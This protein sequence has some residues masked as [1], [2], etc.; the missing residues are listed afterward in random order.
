MR[1][2]K[3]NLAIDIAI[4]TAAIPVFA[5]GFVLL[6]G[7]HV[8]HGIFRESVFHLGRHVWLNIHRIAAIF[9]LSGLVAHVALHW[10]PLTARVLRIF[11]HGIKR[12]AASEL[13]LYLS[14]STMVITGFI[15][16][17]YLDSRMPLFGP[18][19]FGRFNHIRHG[20]IDVHF[21]VGINAFLMAL[22]HVWNRRRWLI[23]RLKEEIVN[24][25]TV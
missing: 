10:K 2:E 5:S 4:F 13:L 3:L 20:W 12:G 22:N 7:F 14:F 25:G 16:W 17:L 24:H 6:F 9:V 21:L 23:N 18:P 11:E 8:S 19:L 15:V 1:R